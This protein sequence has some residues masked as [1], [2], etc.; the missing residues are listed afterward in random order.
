MPLGGAVSSLPA[1]LEVAKRQTPTVDRSNLLV[2]LPQLSPQQKSELAE[3][4]SKVGQDIAKVTGSELFSTLPALEE[5]HRSDPK[6]PEN[7]DR[8]RLEIKTQ[9]VNQIPTPRPLTSCFLQES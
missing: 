4:Q 8:F 1:L 2:T 7:L 9:E 3:Y 5:Q 6:K